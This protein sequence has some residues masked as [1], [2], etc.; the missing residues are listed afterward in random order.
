MLPTNPRTL[1]ERAARREAMRLSKG[2][3]MTTIQF[4]TD[5][6]LRRAMEGVPAN[7]IGTEIDH[8]LATK[9]NAATDNKEQRELLWSFAE[10]FTNEE[11]L[12][13]RTIGSDI[14]AEEQP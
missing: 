6:A 7:R 8:W 13:G 3:I 1:A 9:I 11:L 5:G 10:Q 2:A 14:P 4:D 12:D